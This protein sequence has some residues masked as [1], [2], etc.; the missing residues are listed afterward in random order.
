MAPLL[1][2]PGLGGSGP[3]HWQS[4]W[5]RILGATRVAVPS[6]DA[7]RRATWVAA[8]AAAAADEPIVVAHSLGCA[9][10]AHAAAAGVRFAGALLV[11]PADV[12]AHPPLA[13]FAP[14]P[15]QALPFPSVVVTSDDDPFVAHP[16]AA[17]FARAWGSRLVT[18]P[19]AGHVNVT[20]GHR[21]WDA[22]IGLLWEL[23]T[24]VTRQAEDLLRKSA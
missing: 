21:R 9:A 4:H 7:P 8:L 13:D 24:E 1:I 14:M 5:Q 17:A 10:V 3:E 23:Q 20:S 6:W 15:A 16:R 18:L 19:G 2:A 11:A 22:G 12:E